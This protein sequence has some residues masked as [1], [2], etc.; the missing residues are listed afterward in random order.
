MSIKAVIFDWAGTTID[1]GSRAPLIAFQ[2]TFARYDVTIPAAKIRRDMGMDKIQHIQKL[3]QDPT[4]HAQLAA[5]PDLAGKPL[6]RTL[7]A[8]FK[9]TLLTVLPETV[10][11]KPGI[12]E[13]LTT[14]ADAGIPYGSTSGYDADMLARI[15]PLAAKLGLAPQVNVTS[16]QTDGVGRPAPAMNA[17]AMTQLGIR[18]P[19]H[20][21][22]V[23]DTVNDIL[24]A[25]AAGANSVGI[26]EG[27]NLL[28]FSEAEWAAL[29]A[30]D[31]QQHAEAVR[32][33][34][35][36]AGADVIV[37]NAAALTTLIKNEME[38][39]A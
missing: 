22:I 29:P 20:V 28:A 7:F 3:L 15:L 27:S 10:V 31:Q 33:Q 30:L 38:M 36:T 5:H 6:A 11:L 25:E 13:L 14:L 19:A 2:R 37:P 9:Q 39:P 23:G 16:E 12:A 18:D 21:L 35:A 26:I 24:A 8:Q 1:Y 17:R 4:V 32:R 34:Y